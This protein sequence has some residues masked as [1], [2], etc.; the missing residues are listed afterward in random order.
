MTREF[1]ATNINHCH[2][3]N[4]CLYTKD[5]I[6]VC[7]CDKRVSVII[8]NFP[9]LFH[10][11]FKFHKIIIS[12]FRKKEHLRKIKDANKYAEGKA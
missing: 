1:Q 11:R 10:E 8:K 9:F 2:Y 4:T 7:S 3:S 6:N 12:V 5:N